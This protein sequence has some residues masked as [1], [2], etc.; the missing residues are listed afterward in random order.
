MYADKFLCIDINPICV[1]Q[2]L[3]EEVKKKEKERK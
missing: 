2:L 3:V 1:D